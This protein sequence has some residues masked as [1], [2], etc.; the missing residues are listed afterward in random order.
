VKKSRQES[1]ARSAIFAFLVAIGVAQV[2]L[3]AADP[4]LSVSEY[5]ERLDTLIAAVDASA[6]DPSSL[7]AVGDLPYAWRV[8]RSPRIF[9]IPTASARHDLGAWRTRRDGA[10]RDRLLNTLRTLRSE[11]ASFE[12]PAA[13]SSALRVRLGGILGGDEFRGIHG[14]TWR[15]R[16]QQRI[17][18]LIA[19]VLGR[20]LERSS[21]ATIGNA[22]VYVLIAIAVLLLALWAYRFIRRTAASETAAN[23]ATPAP[24]KREWTAWLADAQAAAAR[25]SWR[26]AIHLVYWCAVSFLEAKGAWRPDRARTPREYLQLVASSRDFSDSAASMAALTRRFELVWYGTDNADAEAF[27]DSIANLKNMGCPTG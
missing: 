26:D 11:A 16:L 27:A 1:V 12:R 24:P 8:G 21:I 10:A 7:G 20:T 6:G 22:I 14:P 3:A 13:D 25:G 17:F 9:E 5:I 4:P 23:I 2:W 19:R 15:D 18:E